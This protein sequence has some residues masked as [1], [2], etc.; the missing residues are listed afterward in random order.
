MRVATTLRC[1][2]AAAVLALA[3]CSKDS[4]GPEPVV[5]PGT[6]TPVE[7]NGTLASGT[8]TGDISITIEG[9]AAS[10]RVVGGGIAFDVSGSRAVV[11][12]SGCL[13]LGSTTCTAVTGTYNTVT[14]VLSFTTTSPAF[15]F[16]GTYSSGRVSGTFTGA[17][18]SGSFVVHSGTVQVFCG[19]FAGDASGVWNLVR[20][21]N[22]VYGIA[23]D[24]GGTNSLQLTGTMSGTTI[25]LTFTG[26]TASGTISGTS[27]SGMWTTLVGDAGT[28]TGST[29]GCRG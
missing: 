18:G 6:G 7:F 27:M 11:P 5:D 3:A 29:S 10:A 28:W 19:T 20:H 14:K 25:N 4:T 26:G 9:S 24:V 15:T 23:V 12:V 21:G 22:D 17:G 16:T 2:T 1:T 13:Y 8:I